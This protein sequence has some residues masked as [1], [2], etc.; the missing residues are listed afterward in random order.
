MKNFFCLYHKL[1][2]EV[3]SHIHDVL[4]HYDSKKSQQNLGKSL[5]PSDFFSAG[6]AGRLIFAS[7]GFT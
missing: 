1:E 7:L 6:T 5:L 2:Y 3:L 4:E